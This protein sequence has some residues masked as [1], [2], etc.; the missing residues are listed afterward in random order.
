MQNKFSTRNNYLP[1]F[2][3][4]LSI[5]NYAFSSGF[6]K[7]I[8][9]PLTLMFIIAIGIATAFFQL[10]FDRYAVNHG[11]EIL[12]TLGIFGCF[13]GIALALL[14]FDTKNINE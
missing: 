13:T 7:I 1:L 9:D 8:K 6:E 12:T 2:L 3:I 5:P 10:K 14:D 11:P 4:F